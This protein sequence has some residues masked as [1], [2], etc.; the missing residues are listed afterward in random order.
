MLVDADGMRCSSAD[1]C[2]SDLPVRQQAPP[3]L[4]GFRSP[5]AAS[6]EIGPV[7][8]VA[9]VDAA[10]RTPRRMPSGS[11]ARL[12]AAGAPRR[13]ARTA[14]IDQAL[15]RVDIPRRQLE[16]ASLVSRAGPRRAAPSARV[17]IRRSA[18]RSRTSVTSPEPSSSVS[19]I[20]REKS[21]PGAQRVGQLGSSP[22]CR[23]AMPP[24]GQPERRARAPVRAA[25]RIRVT[26]RCPGRNP[27]RL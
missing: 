15:E 11:A 22:R 12:A 27:S 24:R 21:M 25:S 4:A 17:R 7:H 23:A 8:P 6:S 26:V 18:P 13:R 20:S 19:S 3:S 2:R 1:R 5:R 16:H 14:A 10:P 9:G